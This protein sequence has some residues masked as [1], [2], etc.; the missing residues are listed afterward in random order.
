MVSLSLAAGPE[1]RLKLYVFSHIEEEAEGITRQ[2]E[3]LG[4]VAI[5]SLDEISDLETL[6]NLGVFSGIIIGARGANV[7]FVSTDPNL[8]EYLTDYVYPALDQIPN[9][10]IIAQSIDETGPPEVV[11]PAAVANLQRRYPG[12]KT[13]IITI[14]ELGQET[15]RLER[16]KRPN[17]FGINLAVDQFN[18]IAG[19]VG[20][21]S[22]ILIFLGLA[23]FSSKVVEAGK[24]PGLQGFSTVLFYSVSIFIFTQ[25]IFSLCSLLLAYPLGLHATI[26]KVTAIGLLGFGGG[27]RPRLLAGIGGML[28]G[29][30][31]TAKQGSR[32]SLNGIIA[33]FT[34]L[35]FL[36]IDPLTNGIFFYELAMVLLVAPIPLP[37]IETWSMVRYFLG[38]ITR[39]FGAWV[40]PVYGISLGITLYYTGAISFYAFSKVTKSSATLLLLFSAFATARGYIRIA[41]MAPWKAIASLIPGLFAGLL[42][43][44]IFLFIDRLEISIRKL[45]NR[46]K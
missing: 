12:L 22:F 20:L 44:G 29:T 15:N 34:I 46:L 16:T 43:F 11:D 19:L 38:T 21:L 8:V 32:I 3:G 24:T 6:T 14:S 17:A 10:L 9:I 1:P 7:F 41:D 31:I 13:K 45:I 39:L 28:F 2:I 36:V 26:P 18:F 4:G 25:T 35:L 37:A 27:N 33:I 30:I 42:F 40:S 23:S 5:T